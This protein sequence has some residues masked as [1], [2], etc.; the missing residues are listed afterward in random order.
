MINKRLTQLSKQLVIITIFTSLS[1]CSIFSFN[2]KP[3]LQQHYSESERPAL[4]QSLMQ[5]VDW[6]VMGK[7]G[8]RT[9]DDSMTAAI[10]KWSQSED[11]FIIEV[12]M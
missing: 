6:K 2:D 8:I 1:A 10:N 9:K 4:K 11:T 5:L 12:L 7:I 3:I